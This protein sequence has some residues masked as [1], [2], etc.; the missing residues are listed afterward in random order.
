MAPRARKLWHGR[1]KTMALLPAFAPSRAVTIS[2]TPVNWKP[3]LG[4]NA[5][6]SFN[7]KSTY[8]QNW[9]WI[10]AT[11]FCQE[12]SDT[13]AFATASIVGPDR[14]LVELSTLITD[15]QMKAGFHFSG[16][17]SGAVYTVIP[18]LTTTQGYTWSRNIQMPVLTDPYFSNGDTGGTGLVA[19]NWRGAWAPNTSYAKNDIFQYNGTSWIVTTGFVSGSTFDSTNA[20]VFATGGNVSKEALEQIYNELATTLPADAGELWLNSKVPQL[21]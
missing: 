3:C 9:W 13:L 21:S 16:G 15:D 7:P 19:I 5:A 20:E 2:I 11:A 17:S 1:T 12:D 14:L 4:V 8:D 18:V 10:D 6:L